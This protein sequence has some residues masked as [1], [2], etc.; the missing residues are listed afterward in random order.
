MDQPARRDNQEQQPPG[1]PARTLEPGQVRLQKVMARA[2]VGSRRACEVLIEAGMVS[3]NG[4][5][6]RSLPCIVDPHE[7]RIEVQGRL[8]PRPERHVYVML[9]KPKQT[10]CTLADPGGRR[11]VAELVDHPSG[12]RLYPVGRLDFDT[13]GLVLMTNDGELANRLTHP[14]YGVHKTYRAIVKGS[15]SDEDVERL[16]QGIYLAERREGRT[17]GARRTA[18]AKLVPVK[19]EPTRT[20]LDV[21]LHEGRNRQVRRMMASAGCPVRRLVRIQMGPIS[22]KG[23]Q[24][25]EWR[26]LTPHELARLRKAARGGD[27]GEPDITTAGMPR[28]PRKG[29]RK[30]GMGDGVMPTPDTSARRSRGDSA[31]PGD[32]ADEKTRPMRVK[33]VREP[34]RAAADERPRAKRGEHPFLGDER[35]RDPRSRPE[36][37]R[38]GGF[39]RGPAR[40]AGRGEFGRGSERGPS[41]G[42]ERGGGRGGSRSDERGPGRGPNRG[43]ARGPGNGSGG[44]GRRG[45]SGGAGRGPSRGPGDRPPKRRG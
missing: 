10:M 23:L 2:G 31:P 25:G 9:Y 16:E 11:T 32:Q 34:G 43:P 39:E 8:L 13:M 4:E 12:V 37:G 41:R 15:L 45:T 35:R 5:T 24:I 19:R 17:V 27:A 22:L 18:R 38:A 3:V 29:G 21:L 20:I 33:P 7:D 36:G 1:Q 40:G 42:S 6:V 28:K 44:A 26:E 14:R 30:P